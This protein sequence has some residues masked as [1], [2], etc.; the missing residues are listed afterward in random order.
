MTVCLEKCAASFNEFK[1]FDENQITDQI[2]KVYAK[3]IENLK[4]I[5]PFEIALVSIFYLFSDFIYLFEYDKNYDARKT[6]KIVI[7]F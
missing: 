6:K 2:Q 4:E 7:F 3:S 1:E 5:E